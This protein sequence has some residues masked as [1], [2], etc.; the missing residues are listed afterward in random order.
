MKK[1]QKNNK[2]KGKN[3]A[4]ELCHLIDNEMLN[5]SEDLDDLKTTFP[6]LYYGIIRHIK[7][8]NSLRQTD[9]T[10][11]YT[12]RGW[13]QNDFANRKRFLNRLYEKIED[14]K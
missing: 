4:F 7:K 10:K 9:I 5:V 12:N 11:L 1:W 14:Y 3:Y 2:N 13:E 8:H 6:E